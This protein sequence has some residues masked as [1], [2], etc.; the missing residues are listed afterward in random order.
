MLPFSYLAHKSKLATGVVVLVF[1][2]SGASSIPQKA[3]AISTASFQPGHIIDD[4]VFTNKN[5]MSVTDI[6]NFLNAKIPSCDTYGL[7]PSSHPN[8]SGG[9]YTRAEWGAMNNNPAPFT[10]LRDYVENPT[11]KQNN[12]SSPDTA[13]SGGIS[14]AQIIWNAAQAYNLNPQVI[15]VTLQK[16]QGLIADDWPW[17]DQYRTAMGYGCPDTAACDSKYFGFYNQIDNAAWQFRYYLDNPGAYNYT[18]GDNYI[19][20]NPSSS[21]GGSV[22]HIE[23]MATAALYIY[24]PYQPNQEALNAGYGAA[25]P[26]GA[27]G[28]RNFWL[29]FNEWFGSTLLPKAFKSSSNPMVYLYVSGYKL[30]VPSMGLLQDFGISPQSI[31][32]LDQSTIDSTPTPT[33]TD[34]ISTGVSYLVKSPS[35]T[36]ADGGAIYLIAVGKKHQ[37]KDMAQFS[38]YGFTTTNIAY[39]PL[40]YIQSFPGSQNLT[41]FMVSPQGTVFHVTSGQK[42]IIV[43]NAKYKALNPSDTVTYMSYYGADLVPSGIPLASIDILVKYT[44]SSGL[45]LLTNG[46]YYAISSYDTYTCWGFGSTFKTLLY[47]PPTNSYISPITPQSSLGCSY[48]DSSNSKYLLSQNRKYQIP[49]A[50]GLTPPTAAA[51]IQTFGNKITTNGSPLKQYVKAG[52]GT[53]V[54]YLE[55]GIRKHVPTYSNFMLLGLDST[56]FDTISGAALSAIPAS[57]IKLGDGQAVKNPG[58]DSV[59]VISGAS[60]IK[61]NNG[62]DYLGYGNSWSSIETYQL[63]AID[64]LYPYTNIDINPYLYYQ[65]NNT[66]YLADP[67]SCYTLDASLLSSFG[68]NQ[69]TIAANQQYNSTI[70]PTFK[71]G[72]CKLASVYVKQASSSTV[73]WIDNGNK[74]PIQ[75]WERLVEHSNSKSPYIITLSPA[76][77]S[78]FPTDVPL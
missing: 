72:N 26:C 76:N 36:D 14:A 11:T 27:Y 34:G 20:Y 21:C 25:P 18:V 39:L 67:N 41:N 30:T 59:Y 55:G 7:K 42:R 58:S 64:S 1:L 54:W 77:L 49:D 71:P 50:Y 19:G 37:F 33:A 43:D 6:Q 46:N 57:G 4:A 53:A 65:A 2:I 31:Q 48:S 24:T 17:Y 22:V 3:E 10:C 35:D 5:A 56:K 75:S 68:K 74:H 61:Y 73:Y 44:D 66:T 60:R 63:N 32:T 29:Y 40:G 51:D 45:Y 38:D 13:I 16:E 62:D 28:N 78:G 8:G 9:Y 70:F 47:Q 52:D 23:N 69:S 12:F 15:L